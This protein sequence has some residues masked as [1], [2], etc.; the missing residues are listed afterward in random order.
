MSSADGSGQRRRATMNDVARHAGVSLGT[1]SHALNHPSRLSAPM[2]ERVRRAI[3]EL[4]FRPNGAA[5][6]LVVGTSA[7]IGMILADLGN[8]YF[9]DLAR[10]A[11]TA[12]QERDMFLT[13]ANSDVDPAKQRTYLELF[14]TERVAGVLLAPVPN[15]LSGVEELRRAGT[16]LVLVDA[17]PEHGECCAA[18][19][20]NELA[21]YLAARHLLEL[22]RSR[23]AFVGGPLHYT[24]IA[25]RLAGARRAVAEAGTVARLSFVEVPGLETGDGRT[26][27][28][29]LGD[30]A[31]ADRPDGIVAASDLLAK[32]LQQVLLGTQ[33]LRIP[34]DVALVA[35]E[36]NRSAFDTI[37]P[38]TTVSLR[39]LDVGAAAGRLLG[40]EIA[41][42]EGHAH[43][44]VVVPPRLLVR[45]STAGR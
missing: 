3:D 39:G 19:P 17:G 37:V 32:G 2:L 35:C 21:G 28:A 9:V 36:D 45:E 8:S 7:M 24:A 16:P 1:V 18:R 20:D 25:D 44:T 22:G 23:L 38:I 42:P 33:G 43:R 12:A 31:A 5:R 34:G 27:G 4:E 6:S 13:M 11:E 40:E 30:L 41:H 10:G 29:M 26:A 15:D 14:A